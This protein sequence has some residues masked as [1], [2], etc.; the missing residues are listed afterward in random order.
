MDKARLEKLTKRANDAKE[1]AEQ[2]ATVTA[3]T[4]FADSVSWGIKDDIF[5]AGKKMWLEKNE[6][7]LESLLST[8]PAEV[9]VAYND[10][11]KAGNPD[12]VGGQHSNPTVQRETTQS[13]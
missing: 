1:L 2:I 9:K 7:Q 13:K 6:K 12:S 10:I 8:E 11:N 4:G 3:A 5:K